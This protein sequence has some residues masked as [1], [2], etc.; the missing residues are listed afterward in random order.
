MI[1]NPKN[2]ATLPFRAFSSE[3]PAFH[4]VTMPGDMNAMMVGCCHSLVYFKTYA[5]SY[6]ENWEKGLA[7]EAALR[8]CR[9]C[10]PSASESDRFS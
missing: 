9:P 2:E 1:C 8:A 3:P 10:R 7:A 4:N 5:E 6:A